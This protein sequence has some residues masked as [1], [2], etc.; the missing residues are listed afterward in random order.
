MCLRALNTKCPSNYRRDH[1][2]KN[3]TR[4]YCVLTWPTW[5]VPGYSGTETS[6]DYRVPVPS[7]NSH[8][9][10][11]RRVSHWCHRSCRRKRG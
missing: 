4:G 6:T 10:G 5:R 8:A 1:D 7:S 9:R 2:F 11:R 3:F